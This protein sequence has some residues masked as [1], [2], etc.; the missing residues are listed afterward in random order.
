MSNEVE[1]TV[2]VLLSTMSPA[3]QA[4]L[5]SEISPTAEEVVDR[6]IRARETAKMLSCSTRTVGALAKAGHLKRVFLPGR[7]LGAG[8]RLSDVKALIAGAGREAA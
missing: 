8:F 1:S 6:I 3:V 5:L 2:R 7:K 4:R